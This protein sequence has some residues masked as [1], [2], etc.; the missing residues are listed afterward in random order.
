MKRK[1]LIGLGIAILALQLVRPAKNEAAE[2]AVN[3]ISKGYA[4]NDEVKAILQKACLDCHSNNTRY[5]WYT[6]IQPL[7][8]W[9]AHHVDEGKD[10]LNFSE[11]MAYKPKK[12]HHK[13]D[14]VVESQEDSWMPLDSYL[15]THKDAKLTKEEKE[16]IIIWSKGIMHEL[17]NTSPALH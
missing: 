13:L 17:Q 10:E 12:Q 1:I 8:W 14:E 4:M 15:W 3:D 7:G 9:M 16:A 5:P 11:F 6:N 2:V